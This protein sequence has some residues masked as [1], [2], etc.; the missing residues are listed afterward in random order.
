MDYGES[1]LDKFTTFDETELD[2]HIWSTED[3]KPKAILMAI[4]G[5]LAH[6]GDYVTIGEYF[7]PKG[8]ITI[9]YDLRGHKQEKTK[10]KKFDH[11]LDDTEYFL[12][13]IKSKYPGIPIFMIGHSMGGSISTLF[14]IE[15]LNDKGDI[16]GV[17]MSSPYFGNAVKIPGIMIALSG[18]LAKLIPNAKLPAEDLTPNLTHDEEIYERHRKDEEK[19]IR[20]KIPTIRFGSE[21]LKSQKR[22]DKKIHEWSHKLLIFIAGDDKL[23]D[24]K[25]TKEQV[26]KIAPDL[27]TQVFYD[28][29][30][31][32]NF[33][34]INR[35]E[36]FSAME[37]WMT[38]LLG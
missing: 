1:S 33:N 38:E 32:E 7:K 31:H 15:R 37:N 36:T 27:V 34:E 5:G 10:L 26:A 8:F 28:Y 21:L 23:A 14:C 18:V 20:G 2:I 17:I 3:P 11:Y 13:W 12:N 22:I 16:A 30:Y 19:G 6:G 24:V 4:H 35:N 9:S 29:N 25:T